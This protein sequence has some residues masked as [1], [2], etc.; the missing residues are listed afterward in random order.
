[1][2]KAIEDKLNAG[3][4]VLLDGGTG[5][6]MQRKGAPMSG[7]VWCALATRSHPDIVRAVHTDYIR[8]GAD[9]ITANTYATSPLILQA[10]D[11]LDQ[12]AELDGMAVRLALEAR[13]ASGDRPVA[14]A[15]S[16]S[17][18]PP[19]I[20][21][22]DKIRTDFSMTEQ[23]LRPL[24]QRK[25]EVLAEAGVEM[26]MMEMMRDLD[27]SLWASEAAVATGLP[28]WMGIAVR[29]REDGQLTG[30]NRENYLLADLVEPLMATGAR[31]AM[32]MHSSV[33]D[34]DA[35]LPMVFEHWSGPV[36]AYPESGY[37]TIPDWVFGEITPEEFATKCAEWR[38]H[39]V[40][41]L[42]GC[43]GITPDHIAAARA[44]LDRLH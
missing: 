21:G 16:M 17:V 1:M 43:C 22:T 10:H 14:V 42:G 23:D 11:M 20:P 29:A 36:G 40:S 41:V 13:D 38:A 25:A 39:G 3:E 37:F 15:G 2:Y 9:I 34:T 35:A 19:V 27:N 32:I 24:F 6:E 5:T 44:A 30:F 4:L 12:M 8:A 31:V 26:I 7:E 33:P 18:M 28:V